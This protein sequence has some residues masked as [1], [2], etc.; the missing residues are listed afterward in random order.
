MHFPAMGVAVPRLHFLTATSR[1]PDCPPETQLLT[2]PILVAGSRE[3]WAFPAGEAV[4]ASPTSPKV[5]LLPR[6]SQLHPHFPSSYSSALSPHQK[7]EFWE[8]L[9][10]QLCSPSTSSH[11]SV[12]SQGRLWGADC[13]CC[14]LCISH[15]EWGALE[16]GRGVDS[17]VSRKWILILCD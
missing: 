16:E 4:S 13:H 3:S 5:L 15:S 11:L 12:S 10:S 8:H 2:G 1:L 14:R 7:P 9:A 6:D 17:R